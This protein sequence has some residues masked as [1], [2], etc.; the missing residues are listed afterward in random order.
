MI[1]QIEDYFV[2]GCGRC[3]RFDTPNCSTRKWISGLL[4]LR[5]I[6][7]DL[8]LQEKLAWGHPCY[9]YAGRN[10]AIFGALIGD[11]RLSF[12]NPSLLKDPEGIL[13]RPGPNTRHPEMIRFT[14]VSQVAAREGLIRSYLKE[15]MGYA[16]SGLTPRPEELELD[17]PVEL[18]NALAGD[19]ELDLA[20]RRLTPGRQRS[21]IIH[22]HSAKTSETRVSR[23]NSYRERILAGKGLHDR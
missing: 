9:A 10:I 13:E 22:L 19:R 6:C 4:A 21:Y 5:K 23:M 2:K 1:T 20:F 11:F 14:D 3:E 8:E 12:F 15:A 16:Q 17:L 7:L 18:G